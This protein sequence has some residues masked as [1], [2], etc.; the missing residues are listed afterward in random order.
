[1]ATYLPEDLQNALERYIAD[2]QKQINRSEA[3][4]MI[5]RTWL[6]DHGYLASLAEEGTPPDQLNASNDD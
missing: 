5:L 1:M 6:V 2:G 3:I 4:A